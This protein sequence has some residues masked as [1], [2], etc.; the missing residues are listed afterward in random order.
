MPATIDTLPTIP[1]S[2]TPAS[3]E[4]IAVSNTGSSKLLVRTTP[5]TKG[6]VV[7]KAASGTR[8]TVLGI[9]PDKVFWRVRYDG[10]PGGE[11]WIMVRYTTAN[12][13]AQALRR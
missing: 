2:A 13:Y 12:E 8:F 5:S 7:A 4:A 11:A 6:K 3:T 10:A 9:S 1:S